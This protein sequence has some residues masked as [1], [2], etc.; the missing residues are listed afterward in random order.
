MTKI[1]NLF[2][3]KVFLVNY[4]DSKDALENIPI[5]CN[6]IYLLKAKNMYCLLVKL[7]EITQTAASKVSHEELAAIFNIGYKL[8]NDGHEQKI[9]SSPAKVMPK[10]A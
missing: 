5:D 2:K 4:D 8:E 1:G 3:E 10:Q 6:S 9:P 7:Q